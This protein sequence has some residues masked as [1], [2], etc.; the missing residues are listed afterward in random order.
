[1][2]VAVHARSVSTLAGLARLAQVLEGSCPTAQLM[3]LDV[4]G[5][6]VLSELGCRLE[7]GKGCCHSRN[8]VSKCPFWMVRRNVLRGN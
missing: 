2:L 1:V 5:S 7:Y 8:H 6:W 3:S 4:C